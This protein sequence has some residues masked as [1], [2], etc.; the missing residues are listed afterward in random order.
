MTLLALSPH[1]DDAAFS[2]GGTL[3]RLAEAGH[4]VVVATVFT[5]SVARP[6]GFALRCQTDKGVPPGADYMAIRRE[7]DAAACAVLGAE[8][9]WLDLPE[10]PH[11]GYDTP[12]ALFAGVHT[13]DERTWRDVLDRLRALAAARAPDLLLSCR[14][15]GTHV[16]HLHTVRAVAA[17]AEETG[18]PAA[19]WRDAPYALRQP[20]AAPAPHLPGDLDE[21]AVVLDGDALDAKLDACAAYATQIGYQ[22]G[23]DAD[24][25]P[26]AALRQ[27]LA[28]FADDEGE[29]LGTGGS[30][31]AWA[32][33]PE[34]LARLDSTA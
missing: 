25:P 15:L 3:A 7:E 28:A 27:R 33:R 22:F 10:A 4:E 2:A 11:R 21:A 23:R 26:E 17:F 34:A 16:D 19:W 1:L 31:E 18:V 12:A 14:G 6:T 5:Q 9:V 30:A 8:A 20:D 29:R 24:G 13:G 32:G